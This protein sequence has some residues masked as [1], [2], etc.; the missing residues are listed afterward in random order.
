MKAAI[1]CCK[2]TY[3]DVVASIGSALGYQGYLEI[4][5]AG[6]VLAA[7]LLIYRKGMSQPCFPRNTILH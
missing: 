2:C 4:A 3:P 7:Y 5:A 6:V 1:Y